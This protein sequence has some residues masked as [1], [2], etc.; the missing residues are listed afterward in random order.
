MKALLVLIMML[1]LVSCNT[2]TPQQRIQRAMDNLWL[3]S[4]DDDR[5]LHL[6]PVPITWTVGN[7]EGLTLAATTIKPDSVHIVFD[8]QEISNKHEWL[9]PIIAHEIDHC[10]DA[11]NVYGVEQFIGIVA[12][13]KEL[14]WQDRTVEKSAIGQENQTRRYL[15]QKY[16]EYRGNLPYRKTGA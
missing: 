9:E 7:L 8:W 12:G 3:K 11:Y 15:L 14:P 4:P 13:E 16:P 10:N 2:E 1:M 5:K 6:I